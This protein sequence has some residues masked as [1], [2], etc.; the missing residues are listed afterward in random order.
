MANVT[1]NQQALSCFVAGLA[2]QFGEAVG[3]TVPFV[4]SLTPVD[5]KRLYNSTRATEPIVSGKLI[6]CDIVAGGISL[7]GEIREQ[8]IRRDVD[9]AYWVEIRNPYIRSNLPAIGQEII[10]N[11]KA[12]RPEFRSLL[13]RGERN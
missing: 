13:R 8:E 12:K 9:Y 6:E 7:Y 3:N 2:K 4:Q 10:A 11:L 5:T 1:I